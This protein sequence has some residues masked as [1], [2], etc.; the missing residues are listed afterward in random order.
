MKLF[1]STHSAHCFVYAD[2]GMAQDALESKLEG[3][4]H[5]FR[6]CHTFARLQ[7]GERDLVPAGWRHHTSKP[8]RLRRTAI[9]S[10]LDAGRE[11]YGSLERL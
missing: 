7:L 3:P 2:Y 5:G 9:G 4:S 11:T 10:P 8:A 1:G 6:G